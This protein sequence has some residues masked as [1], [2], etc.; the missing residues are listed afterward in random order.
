MTRGLSSKSKDVWIIF[1]AH[2]FGRRL[3]DY[4]SCRVASAAAF[5]SN[6]SVAA[7]SERLES[8]G[9]VARPSPAG[10][11]LAEHAAKLHQ[12]KYDHFLPDE[13]LNAALAKE[14]LD[15]ESVPG[16]ARRILNPTD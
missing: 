11:D 15:P 1:V 8:F 13:L 10:S 2:F 9:V 14:R 7:Q 16:V 5:A 3:A 12:E 4:L 6:A